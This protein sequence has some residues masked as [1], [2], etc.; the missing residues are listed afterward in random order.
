MAA[1]TEHDLVEQKY[2][3]AVLIQKTYRGYRARRKLADAAIMSKTIGWWNVV[4]AAVLHQHT[5][6]YY[7]HSKS[8]KANDNW[9]RLKRKASKLGKGL[10]KNNKALKLALNHWLEAIDARHRYGHNLRPY[11]L[12]WHDLDTTEP[13]FYWLDLGCGRQIELPKISRAILH[14]QQITYLSPDQRKHFEVAI[15]HG[16]LY[17][18][19]SGELVH[20]PSG[21]RWIFVMSPSY[22]LYIGKKAKGKF[23]H[24]SF[25][26]GGATTAAGRLE[27]DHG[28]LKMMEA[29]SGH[30]KP[31]PENFEALVGILVNRGADLHLAKVQLVSDDLLEK[32]KAKALAQEVREAIEARCEEGQVDVKVEDQMLV[33]V[34]SGIDCHTEYVVT[35]LTFPDV[36]G[37]SIAP[38]AGESKEQVTSRPEHIPNGVSV[39]SHG[40]PLPE[41]GQKQ[42]P[43]IVEDKPVQK[44]ETKEEQ[45]PVHSKEEEAVVEAKPVHKVEEAVV[46]EQPKIKLEPIVVEHI[47]I[48]KKPPSALVVPVSSIA[49]LELGLGPKTATLPA[50][51]GF[52]RNSHLANLGPLQRREALKKYGPR[53]IAFGTKPQETNPMTC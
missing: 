4:D 29:H 47:L 32:K 22:K 19:S 17:Y 15:Y 43:A 20:T 52:S 38:K 9:K 3:S 36:A 13:F 12:H 45:K 30:Y 37:L 25:L 39:P 24:S 2:P 33:S 48:R 35:S 18:Q 14:E 31:S 11:Y 26:A 46:E 8:W 44:E 34:D 16:K 5:L 27:T 51:P 41:E 21:E 10:E 42:E 50:S 23:Q 40:V 7:A 28:V 49:E 1:E 53:K 6:Q